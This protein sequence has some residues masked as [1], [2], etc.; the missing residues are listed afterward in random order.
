MQ[1]TKISEFLELKT[2]D[3]LKQKRNFTGDKFKT[4]DISHS[5]GGGRE[6]VLV[7]MLPSLQFAARIAQKQ[8]FTQELS[9][10]DVEEKISTL[11]RDGSTMFLLKFVMAR[12]GATFHH[13][14][15]EWEC[16]FP[17]LHMYPCVYLIENQA[18][19]QEACKEEVSECIQA[20]N[21]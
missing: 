19:L 15:R 3:I 13:Q 21:K 5:G 6:D 7:L 8:L 14:V 9:C 4:N 16:L 2:S 20:G 1:K 11:E 10:L 12:S 18:H 17:T